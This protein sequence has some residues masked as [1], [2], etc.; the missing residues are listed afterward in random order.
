VRSPA[1]TPPATGTEATRAWVERTLSSG[2]RGL[3][4][5]AH[6]VADAPHRHDRRRVAE[7]SAQLADVDVHR[8]SV[9]CER[10]PPDPL[11]QLVARQ[12]EPPVIEQLPQQIELLRRQ[13]D[14]L[15]A[16]ARLAAA[17][18]DDEIAVL[19]HRAL[20]LRMVRCRPPK[21]RAHSC[22]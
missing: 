5:R 12:D 14:L 17:G 21:N 2:L 19:D 4:R 9:A 7:L 1:G 10:V 22:H 16:D 13:L 20:A 15:V 18:V 6:L 3:A 8:A 11:E